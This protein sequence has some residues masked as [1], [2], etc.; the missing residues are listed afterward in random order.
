MLAT[1]L[2]TASVVSLALLLGSGTAAVATTTT[3][4]TAATRTYNTWVWNVAGWTMNG[5]STTNGLIT[6]ITDSIRNRSAD[7][8]ALNEVCRGQYVAVIE[9]L[10]DLG[11]PEDDSNFARF[12][13]S[14]STACDGEP[15]GNAIFSKAPLGTASH[16][17]LSSDGSSEDRTLLCAPLS[18]TP[19]VV[20]C[21]AHITP[22]DAIIDGKNINER[23]LDEVHSLMETF[24]ALGL[25]VILAGDLN[26]EP[27]L[28]PLNKW[29]SSSLNTQYN[30]ANYG[31][32]RELDDTDTRCAGYGEITV[33]NGDTGGPCGLGRKI[34]FI[35]V[36]EN[37]LAGSYTGDSLS[38]STVCGGYC[39]DHRIVI[40][41]ATVDVNL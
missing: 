2:I 15:F 4:A 29:Y 12:E 9:K 24:N 38:I 21:A 27:N 11:W 37:R 3:T 19:K 36:R 17:T 35:F 40:G 8:A 41:T 30:S 1:R 31:S 33:D 23:Q 13:T 26:N 18:A 6:A 32:Y 10:R 7:F 39:S 14:H 20:F 16:Y 25:T 5:A 28:D 22:S 34:D